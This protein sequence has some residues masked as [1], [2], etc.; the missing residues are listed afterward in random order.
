MEF[1]GMKKIWDAQN[2]KPLYVINE[3]ALHRS[4][5]AKKKR[6]ICMNNSNDFG[7]TA[8]FIVT[9]IIILTRTPNICDYL[10]VATLLL[11]ICYIWVGRIRRKKKNHTF[12]RTLL[13]DLNYAL[14][15]ITYEAKRSKSMV[16]WFVL[17]LMILTFLNMS[18]E[19]NSLWKW[20][21]IGF[22]FVLSALLSRWGYNRRKAERQKLETLRDKLNEATEVKPL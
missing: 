14:S 6:A 10:I 11:I 1:E 12:G 4:I 21:G 2:E 18:Q 16:W 9:I 7:L 19:I 20:M 17:P 3:E 8:I 5:M 22:A 13:G 15:S